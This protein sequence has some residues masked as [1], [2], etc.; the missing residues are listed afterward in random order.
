MSESPKE[1]LDTLLGFLGFVVNI[2]EQRTNNALVLQIFTGESKRLIG[3]RGE[4]LDDIQYLVNRLVQAQDPDA[5]RV[6]V[7]VEHYRTMQE[8]ELVDQVRRMAERVRI[9]GKPIQLH[10]MNSYDRY[11]VHNLFKDDPEIAT[12]SPSDDARVKRITIKKRH[13]SG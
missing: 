13:P 5:P 4:V 10:P 2:E 7:D 1:I 12:W 11:I 6:V 9:T 8:D 3:R